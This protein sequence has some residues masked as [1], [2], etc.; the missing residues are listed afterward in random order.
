MFFRVSDA[1]QSLLI[2]RSSKGEIFGAYCSSCW[3]ERRDLAERLKTRYFGTGE[4]F[5]WLLH[6]ELKFPVIYPWIGQSSDNPN[7][8]PQMFM[9]AGD[10]FLIVNFLFFFTNN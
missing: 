10:K 1:D 8:C 7:S 4:S 9:T 2:I 3:N 6:D 5:V